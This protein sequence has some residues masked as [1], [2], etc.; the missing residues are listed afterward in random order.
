ATT[1]TAAAGT[2]TVGII[3]ALSLAMSGLAT[4]AARAATGLRVAAMAHPVTA[5]VTLTAALIGGVAAW[6][7]FTSGASN[8][9]EEILKAQEASQQAA[10]GMEAL[11]TAL[12]QDT[13]AWREARNAAAEHALQQGASADEA[14]RAAN[15]VGNAAALRVLSTEELTQAAK[16]ERDELATT[17]RNNLWFQESLQGNIEKLREQRD[18]MQ[19]DTSV[20]DERIAKME[21]L[22]TTVEDNTQA[23][24]QQNVAIGAATREWAAASLEAAFMET[25]VASSAEAMKVLRDTGVTVCS[26]LNAELMKA[27][28]GAEY[29]RQK[30]DEARE[31]AGFWDR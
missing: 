27:G 13:E 9:S 31:A 21:S 2:R 25:N 11:R 26:V 6:D 18:A 8:S 3:G 24:E 23:V 12:H 16:D 15:R 17:A 29:F 10:G 22:Q 4:A 14:E 19:G 1:A 7:A 20:L 28:D 30:A 5:V